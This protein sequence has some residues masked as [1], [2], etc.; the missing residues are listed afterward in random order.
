VRLEEGGRTAVGSEN[1]QTGKRKVACISRFK[2]QTVAAAHRPLHLQPV[3]SVATLS[4]AFCRA[5]AGASDIAP[6]RSEEALG[7]N[8]LECEDQPA[9]AFLAVPAMAARQ[10]TQRTPTERYPNVWS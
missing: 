9:I 1:R 8:Q 7:A 5:A 6:I 4:R 3:Q 10:R 2:G